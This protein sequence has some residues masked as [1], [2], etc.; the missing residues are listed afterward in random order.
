MESK[1]DQ[2]RNLR[3]FYESFTLKLHDL[4]AELIKSKKIDLVKIESRTKSIESFKGKIER[5][6]KNY[7][8]PLNQIT[9]FSGIRIITYYN[10]DVDIITDLIKQEFRIDES[11]SVDKR[12]I[13]EE[14]RFGYA[15]S[16]LVI[17][18][19]KQR[20]KLIEWKKFGRLKAEIQVRSILQHS[21][22]SIDHK[23]RYKTEFAIPHYIKRK[24]YRLSALLELAD[25]EFTSIK[26]ISEERTKEIKKEVREGKLSIEIDLNSIESYVETSDTFKE[27]CSLLRSF[28][29]KIGKD[30]G[31]KGGIMHI[32]SIARDRNYNLLEDFDLLLKR[33]LKHNI[34]A[35]K[36]LG[37]EVSESETSKNRK[38]TESSV[39]K[40][41]LVLD[42]KP[43]K[44]R[45]YIKRHS[46]K[47]EFN[48]LIIKHIK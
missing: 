3:P 4:L 25:E 29:F 12:L 14:D 28:G 21:W 34:Q 5:D 22:A 42:S 2:Y 44:A 24:L 31:G 10:T 41:A 36:Q 37:N 27:F 11:N 23:L 40:L 20:N 17:S 35:Y 33:Q 19:D 6:D 46:F 13:S 18:L 48:E 16:H 9:D 7:S 8:D 45:N 15:S 39:I 1:V 30:G 43:D 47:K 32:I 26:R 38:L